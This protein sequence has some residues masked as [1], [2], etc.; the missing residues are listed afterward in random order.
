MRISGFTTTR[1]E[2]SSTRTAEDFMKFLGANPARLGIVSTLYD[3]YTATHLTEAL[4]NT[5]TL[6]KGKKNAFQSIDSFMV[7]WDIKVNRIKRVPFAAVPVGDGANGSDIIFHFAENYYQRYDTFIVEKT[8]QMI[9]VINRPQRIRDNDFVV[10][11]KIL[12]D[13]YSSVLDTTGCQVGDKTRFITN[14]QPEMHE[15]GYTKYQ[16]NTEKHRTYIATHRTDVDMS[17]K[18]LPMEDTF[19]QIGKGDKDDP[20]YVM[21][22][23]EKDCLDSFMDV[24]G[25]ALLWGKSNMDV[26]GKPKIYDELGRP[27]ISSDGIIAQINRFAVKFSFTHLNSKYFNK[28]IQSMVQRSEKPQGNEYMFVCNTLMYNE[29]QDTLSAWIRDWKTVGTFLFSKASNNYVDLGATYQSYTYAGNTITFKI[30]RS[31]D[32]EYPTRKFGMFLDLTADAA[33]GK[34]A[35]NEF[36]FKGGDFIHNYI[37]G[38]GGKSGLDPGEVSSPV[39]ASK[40]INWGY[41]GVGVYNPYRSVVLISEEVTNPLF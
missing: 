8:R 19:I 40:L 30:D 37:V 5:Y 20:V 4:L 15:E 35:L 36:T 23:A 3:Q 9:I 14:Y 11:G 34:P 41:A 21:N 29:I 39:A 10:I 28:A 18:Y 38:V 2:M 24:R 33:S 13:D 16:S 27:I 31:I 1:P 22:S 25:N 6:E 12:D 17:A 7:E 26:N 32:V